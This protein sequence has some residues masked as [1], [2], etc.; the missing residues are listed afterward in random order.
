MGCLTHLSA[1]SGRRRLRPGGRRRYKVFAMTALEIGSMLGGYRI[2]GVIGIDERGKPA[3]ARD[4]AQAEGEQARASRRQRP[5]ELGHRPLAEELMDQHRL[6]TIHMLSTR[7]DATCRGSPR[8]E[9]QRREWSRRSPA[10]TI[11]AS[12]ASCLHFPLQK[13]WKRTAGWRNRSD[14]PWWV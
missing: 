5:H 12:V 10:P 14:T 11:R 13:H 9:A 4:V 1:G 7:Q 8:Q 3:V 6:H 2:E